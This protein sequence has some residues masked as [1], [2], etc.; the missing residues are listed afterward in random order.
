MLI[1][2]MIPFREDKNLGRAYNEAMALLPADGWAIFQDHDAMPTTPQWFRQFREAIEFRP[3][4][5]AFAAMTNRIASPWQQVGDAKGNDI[6]AHRAFGRERLAVRTLLD[7]T[8]TKGWGGV[9]FAV[10]RAAWA[11]V[12]GFAD[13]FYCVDHSLHFKLGAAGRRSYLI[14][15]VYVFHVRESSSARP[16][17]VAPKVANCPCRGRE[18]MPSA[19]I[20]LPG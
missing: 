17:L 1:L 9:M 4:A 18:T 12:G 7:V 19:R 15:G 5:G 2:P 16:P 3:Y 14:E 10:S 6:A 11:E 13:G 20:T 8:E